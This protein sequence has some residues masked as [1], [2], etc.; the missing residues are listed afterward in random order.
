MFTILPE[1]TSHWAVVV[2][3]CARSTFGMH[4]RINWAARKA[5]SMTN[6]KAPIAGGRRVKGI[7][8][9]ADTRRSE[10]LRAARNDRRTN[11]LA[12]CPPGS[13]FGEGWWPGR[14]QS[15]EKLTAQVY[16]QTVLSSWLL[17]A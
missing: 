6:S 7:R 13:C 16:S 2:S 8:R 14:P 11:K 15:S 1:A 10:K 17:E 3:L 4:P 5:E 12:M 9:A